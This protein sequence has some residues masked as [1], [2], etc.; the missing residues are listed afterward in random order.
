[1]SL[2][3]TSWSYHLIFMLLAVVRGLGIKWLKYDVV[4]VLVSVP[5]VFWLDAKD[6][7]RT[8]YAIL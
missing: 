3:L 4:F 6:W 2:V 7:K 1:M 5:C 8:V